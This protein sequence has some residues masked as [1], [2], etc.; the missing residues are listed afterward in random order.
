[1]AARDSR[2]VLD[3]EIAD[4]VPQLLDETGQLAVGELVV[5]GSLFCLAQFAGCL[6]P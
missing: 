1:M 5:A 2:K 3:C 4:A 6:L